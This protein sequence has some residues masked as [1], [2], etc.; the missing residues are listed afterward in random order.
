VLIVDDH[1][2]FAEAMAVVVT[3]QHDMTGRAVTS[4][5]EAERAVVDDRPDVVLLGA[6]G[7]DD[8]PDAVSRLLEHAPDLR[9]LILT[10]GEDDQLRVRSSR[11][12]AYGSLTTFE[13]IERVLEAI[14]AAVNGE[15][16]DVRD[17]EPR[18]AVSGRRRRQ[19]HAT[20]HQR[21]DRLSPREREI[22]QLMANGSEPPQ[23]ATQ[24]G[25]SPAT[26]RTHIQNILTKLRVHSKT[27]AVLM[28]IRQGKV[29]GRR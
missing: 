16:V 29:S 3:T 22:L 4:T 25:I 1:R 20:E 9:I 15:P 21:S 27:Q 8:E 26:L 6:I 2:T 12:G 23:I 19:P 13:P 11:A 24:L 10:D 5:S 7:A 18:P 28:A 14:R 17:E